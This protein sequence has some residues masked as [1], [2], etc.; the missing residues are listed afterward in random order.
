MFIVCLIGL[1]ISIVLAELL[2][3][4]GVFWLVVVGFLYFG[5]IAVL[6]WLN[7]DVLSVMIPLSIAF[8]SIYVLYVI[9]R[10][11]GLKMSSSYTLLPILG[12][13]LIHYWVEENFWQAVLMVI[14]IGIVL[15]GLLA[16]IN[17]GVGEFCKRWD[18][19]SPVIIDNQCE[20]CGSSRVI[21]STTSGASYDSWDEDYYCKR[22]DCHWTSINSA[23]PVIV[24]RGKVKRTV[25]N[26]D[27]HLR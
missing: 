24:K 15:L 26:I 18:L 25:F 9:L 22:C 4:L 6:G 5:F 12:Y 17:V 13:E 27:K 2:K 3:S 20:W 16:C 8:L 10:S 1:I 7:H 21:K 11:F 14:V 23:P 19:E